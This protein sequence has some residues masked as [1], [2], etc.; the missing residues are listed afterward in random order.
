MFPFLKQNALCSDLAVREGQRFFFPRTQKKRG[1]E[2]GRK[3][4]ERKRKKEREGG[5]WRRTL[6]IGLKASP[7]V[8]L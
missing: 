1:R 5:G 2:G 7:L 4:R 8:P 6:Q 3:R